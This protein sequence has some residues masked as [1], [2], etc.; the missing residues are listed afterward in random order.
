MS[1]SFSAKESDIAIIGLSCKFPGANNVSE[2]WHNLQSGTESSTA[3]SDDELQA[4]GVLPAK[5]Q[6]PNYVKANNIIPDVD[7]FDAGFFGISKKE[8]E[9]IDPQQRLFLEHAYLTLE[10]A[11]YDSLTYEGLIGVYAGIGMNTYILNNLRDRYQ[12]ASSIEHYRLMLANDKDFLPTRI[13]YKLDLKGPSLLINTACSTSLVVVHMACLSLL[14]GECDMALA[15]CAA[16]RFPQV[17]GYEYQ[18]EMIFSPDGHCRA[19]DSD[20]QGTILGDGLGVIL[21]KRLE[22]AIADRDTIHCLIRG[23]AI[24]ND[25]AIKTGFTAPSVEGQAKVILEALSA[26]DIEADSIGY[27]E[28]HGTGTS[29][30]D[31][32]EIEALTQAYHAYTDAKGYCALGSVKTNIGHLDVAAGMAG[33]IKTLLMLKHKTLVPTLHYQRANPD[34]DFHNSPFFVNTETTEWCSDGRPRR[35]GVSSFGIGGTNAH[36]I[37]EEMPS[38]SPTAETKVASHL[39]ML[40]AKTE[41]ALQ[42]ITSSLSS[43]LKR[44]KDIVLG[45]VAF[46]LSVGRRAYPYRAYAI[47]ED[48]GDAAL[49]LALQEETHFFK[50]NDVSDH[51]VIFVLP[52][53]IARNDITLTDELYHNNLQY[54]QAVD[55]CAEIVFNLTGQDIKELSDQTANSIN[56]QL[57]DQ[58]RLFTLEYALMTMWHTLGVVPSAI[59]ASG[60]S[61][62]SAAC[63]SGVFSPELVLKFICANNDLDEQAQSVDD[64]RQRLLTELIKSQKTTLSLPKTP[65]KLGYDQHRLT[66]QNALD[67]SYWAKIFGTADSDEHN[68]T[69][70][71]F[72]SSNCHFLLYHD[73]HITNTFV[74]KPAGSVGTI[75]KSTSAPNK[76]ATSLENMG[77]LW[78][79][80]VKARY[81][82]LYS[83]WQYQRIPLVDYPFERQRYWI[84]ADAQERP[85]QDGRQS[86]L[87]KMLQ[88]KPAVGRKQLLVSHIQEEFTNIL[89]PEANKPNE[90]EKL[91]DL[92]IESLALIEVVAK[93]GT[94][95]EQQIPPSKIVEYPTIA[96]FAEYILDQRGLGLQETN[97]KATQDSGED[98]VTAVAI[99][100]EQPSANSRRQLRKR[101]RA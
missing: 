97:V 24:N 90:N 66:E 92:G 67:V 101:L 59:F 28:A 44:N 51:P 1:T 11:G 26:A 37:M 31:P 41:K 19:F 60:L 98:S 42:K 79:Q 23:S 36:I 55:E 20:A 9:I 77:Q 87:L 100:Q 5:L 91:L 64:Q 48:S 17:A 39:L 99:T 15:G 14:N 83:D 74:E 30:G 81:E 50:Q 12:Q 18:E 94:Q 8:A 58:I 27:V 61:Q 78:L 2:F 13:S 21:L 10:N 35:A 63:I 62:Y 54:R 53:N 57:D 47:C 6:N 56:T 40:S 86:E 84:E 29:L 71:S 16:I 22:D 4:A 43:H 82:L 96:S 33:L 95:L 3:F 75:V 49:T 65:L 72:E 80:G 7:M 38:V 89:G 68:I 85:H 88:E 25:G 69:D 45:D 52:G 93:L 70:W 73:S 32:I 46:T 34:I 76:L